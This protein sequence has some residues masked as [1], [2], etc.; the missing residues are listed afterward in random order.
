MKESFS[1]LPTLKVMSWG[2][3]ATGNAKYIH[4]R[5][6]Y[7]LE[8]YIHSR[9]EQV[10]AHNLWFLLF[11]PD[12]WPVFAN[13]CIMPQDSLTGTYLPKRSLALTEKSVLVPTPNFTPICFFFFH[14]CQAR[15]LLAFQTCPWSQQPKNCPRIPDL[16]MVATA[17][18]LS[19]HQH[20]MTAVILTK[21]RGTFYAT[22]SCIQSNVLLFRANQISLRNGSR[23]GHNTAAR[24]S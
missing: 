5:K 21:V 16:P 2:R 3:T 18:E 20:V 8:E 17:Q 13:L 9:K 12:D 7:I 22:R 10:M 15:C 1:H 14:H 6:E 19:S 24:S 23:S 11:H 4:S